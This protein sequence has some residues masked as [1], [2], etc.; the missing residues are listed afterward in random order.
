MEKN[1]LFAVLVLW[2]PITFCSQFLTDVGQR[3]ITRT[4]VP[5]ALLHIH[6]TQAER[7]H[8]CSQHTHRALLGARLKPRALGVGVRVRPLTAP[9]MDTQSSR[10]LR[11]LLGSNGCQK[12]KMTG[13]WSVHWKS[14]CMFVSWRP[15]QSCPTSDGKSASIKT[16]PHRNLYR[17]DYNINSFSWVNKVS[18][19]F[20]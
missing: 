12:V 14:I 7:G 20:F 9:Q 18:P 2:F 1:Y 17:V 16:L 3:Q 5:A 15:I 11:K 8:S 4:V 13:V 19:S 6:D 10:V